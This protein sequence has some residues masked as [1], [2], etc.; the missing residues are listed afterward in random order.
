MMVK[1]NQ[2]NM[3]SLQFLF[4]GITSIEHDLAIS[5]VSVDAREITMGG[6]FLAVAGSKEHGLKYASQAIA[7]GANVIA[8]DPAAGGELLARELKN[9]N[10][11]LLCVENLALQASEIANR[12]YDAPS[13]KQAVIGITGTNGKTS[14]SHYLAQALSVNGRCGVIGTLGWGLV[15]KL[16]KTINTT[17]DAVS[18]QA[19]LAAMEE[20]GADAIAME[21]SSHGLSQGRVAAVQFK[22]A[23]FTNLSHDHLDYH[24]SMAAY[25]E[26]KKV[27]FTTKG[28][29]F[30]VLNL[31]DEF[32]E[33]ILSSLDE[34]VAV[35]GISRLKSAVEKINLLYIQQEQVVATGIQFSLQYGEQQAVIKSSLLGRFNVDNLASTI[36]VQLGLGLSFESAVANIRNVTAVTGRMQQIKSKSFATKTPTVVVDFAHTPDALA[37][38]LSNL[39]ESC[40]GQLIAVFG[41]G[42]DRDQSKRAEMGRVAAK[43]ANSIIL[44]ADNPRSESAEVI[45]QQIK[46]GIDSNA[47]VTIE[48]DRKK[49]IELAIKIAEQADTV[50]IAGKGHE[51]YQEIASTKYRFSDIACAEKALSDSAQLVEVVCKK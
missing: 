33:K 37:L 7:N 51:D 6:V 50:L 43:F 12:F 44:T 3:P 38:A 23:A 28:L 31:D 1:L 5:M 16:T 24:G 45:A 11:L 36:A 21:V 49:A 46:S 34:K 10:V 35:Y 26:A 14:V 20:Q 18:V 9:S 17:P 40:K 30:A 22:G 2:Q 39:K 48:L 13:S 4:T 47:Q 19:Q 25:G 42:G 27:L 8:Y 32:S 41:C 29:E 15:D